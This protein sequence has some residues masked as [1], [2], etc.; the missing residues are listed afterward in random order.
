MFPDVMRSPK[1]MYEWDGKNSVGARHQQIIGED[2]NV[3]LAVPRQHAIA[4]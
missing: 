1:N 3:C 2:E 4:Q